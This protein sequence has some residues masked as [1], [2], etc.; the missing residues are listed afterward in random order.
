MIRWAKK[1]KL[2][3]CVLEKVEPLKYNRPAPKYISREELTRLIDAMSVK[4]R[5]MFTCLYNAGLRKAE[6]C[7]LRVEKH[8]LRSG[9]SLRPGKG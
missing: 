8:I 6:A 3:D 7:T 2:C 1:H 9:L 4:H 5:A